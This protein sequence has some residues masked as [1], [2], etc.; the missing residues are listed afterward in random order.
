[1]KN[2]YSSYLRFSKSQ[3]VA[4]F[5]LFM[6]LLSV[7]LYGLY[8]QPKYLNAIQNPPD[9]ASLEF[10]SIEN[11]QSNF[12]SSKNNPNL[13]PFDPNKLSAEQWQNL[14]FSARQVEVILNYKNRLGGKFH[15]KKQIQD[16]YVI[17]DYKFQ[18]IAPYILL[19]EI[20][21]HDN[22]SFRI[23]STHNKIDTP[24]IHYKKFNPNNYD[25]ND[26]MKIGFSEK[27]ATSILKYK[28]SL[29][30]KFTSLEQIQASY[31]ITEKKFQEMKPYIDL[32]S[33][34]EEVKVEEKSTEIAIATQPLGKFNPNEFTR[35]QW[36]EIGF[37][38][39][40]VNTIFNYKKSLGGKFKDAATLKKCY[41]ISDEK[42]K[43]IEPYLV[44]D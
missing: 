39:K 18:Q 5:I 25:V 4:L 16:C 29:G 6:A 37:T 13:K 11:S 41:S 36:M 12:Q 17:N 44:F 24:K 31:V 7:E 22:S 15:S 9:F 43:E 42:F 2:F 8:F 1:M 33:K 19:P 30:G 21:A 38:E 23:N 26:W 35:E 28:K 3:R 27:Q 10:V 34:P 14:G 20:S 40:Q 32:P